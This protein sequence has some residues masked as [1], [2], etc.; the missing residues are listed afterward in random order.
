[1]QVS[2]VP[3]FTANEILVSED[4]ILWYGNGKRIPIYNTEYGKL[5]W[6]NSNF[7]W[8]FYKVEDIIN[9]TFH[10]ADLTRVTG[11]PIVMEYHRL[12]VK[13][14]KF[15]KDGARKQLKEF[16]L[17]SD[18]SGYNNYEKKGVAFFRV[19]EPM[20]GTKTYERRSLVRD[21]IY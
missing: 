15:L 17:N 2:R 16:A 19:K 10:N 18:T 7:N 6:M 11:I 14:G 8:G 5:A 1:M 20:S 3:M 4:G 9:H 12:D 13:T 21:V